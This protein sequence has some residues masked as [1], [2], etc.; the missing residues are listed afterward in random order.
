[1]T[2]SFGDF[3]AGGFA[4]YIGDSEQE[5][6]NTLQHIPSWTTTNLQVS[7]MAPWNGKLTLGVRN[8][9][10]RAPP[11]NNVAFASPFYSNSQYDF[12]GRV[13]YVRYEQNF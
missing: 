7:W 4:T 13:P 8:I 9:G 5:I 11:L 12:Y 2:W 10:D 1:M 6:A 3:S